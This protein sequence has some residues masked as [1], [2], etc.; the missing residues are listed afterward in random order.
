MSHPPTLKASAWQ[1]RLRRGTG[2]AVASVHPSYATLRREGCPKSNFRRRSRLDTSNSPPLFHLPKKTRE[3]A[4]FPKLRPADLVILC[5]ALVR[6]KREV[7]EIPG[8]NFPS[9]GKSRA[10]EGLP[11]HKFSCAPVPFQR[12]DVFSE[13][14]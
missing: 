7:A 9:P 10:V 4:N 6:P 1:A 2:S 12:V 13:L 5:E 8:P 11:W 14:P 3:T